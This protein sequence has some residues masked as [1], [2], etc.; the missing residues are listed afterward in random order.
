MKKRILRRLAGVFMVIAS[1]WLLTK[2][3][4]DATY[5]CLTV[6]LGLCMIFG[7]RELFDD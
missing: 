5:V 2:C 6:P 3:D 4:G 7:S 1:L